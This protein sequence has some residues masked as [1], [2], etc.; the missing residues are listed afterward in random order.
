M[1]K[2]NLTTRKDS[3]MRKECFIVQ[4]NKLFKKKI[5]ENELEIE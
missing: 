4:R 3:R 2:I 5:W 1:T